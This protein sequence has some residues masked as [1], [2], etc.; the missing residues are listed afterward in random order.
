[1]TTAAITK[2]AT[3][4]HEERIAQPAPAEKPLDA[5]EEVLGSL[6]EPGQPTARL[7][8]D[9]S[10]YSDEDDEDMDEAEEGGVADDDG[11]EAAFAGNYHDYYDGGSDYDYGSD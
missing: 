11:L 6:P 1:M 4:P 8:H 3:K 7:A 2:T 10:A 9:P 5:N